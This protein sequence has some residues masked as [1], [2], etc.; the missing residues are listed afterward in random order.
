MKKNI[1]LVIL[2][3]LALTEI[4]SGQSVF[5]AI[6]LSNSL[7]DLWEKGNIDKAVKNSLDLYSIDKDMFADRIHADLSQ[8][9]KKQ[10][11]QVGLSYL[12][13]LYALDDVELNQLIGPILL[14]SRAL[15]TKDAEELAGIQQELIQMQNE[16]QPDISRSEFY[17]LLILQDLTK[18]EAIDKATTQTILEKNINRLKA[19]PWIY[20]VTTDRKKG[21]NRAWK[22]YLIANSYA[23]LF[24]NV[25]QRVDYL[26]KAADYSPDL[27]DQAYRGAY[28][29]DAALLTDNTKEIGY[30]AKYQEFLLANDQEKVTLEMLAE[31]AFTEPTDANMVS[32]KAL[33]DNSGK[34]EPFDQYWRN[35]IHNKGR[36]MPSVSIPFDSEVLDFAKT[37]DSW[38]YVYVWGTWCGPCVQD[39]PNLQAFY[40]KNLEAADEKLKIYTL[41]FGSRN[42]QGFMKKKG[43]D[44]PVSEITHNMTEVLGIQGYPTKMLISPEGNYVIIPF[45]FDWQS[46]LRNYVLL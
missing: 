25:E 39:L 12:E 46:Y 3:F 5:K 20:E 26:A 18:K 22:R 11:S 35:F 7:H 23:T 24:S 14:W 40:Q 8:K 30:K 36:P 38:T 32:L 1:S 33:Y 19:D 41:S 28:F 44:F 4:A 2:V 34:E 17:V 6:R 45:G 9:I 37:S 29:Y 31:L 13:Q 15:P 27:Y 16:N 43:Y 10:E 42:L 21:E